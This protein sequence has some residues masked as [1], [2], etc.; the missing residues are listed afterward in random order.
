MIWFDDKGAGGN[1][2]VVVMCVCVCVMCVCAAYM[3]NEVIFYCFIIFLECYTKYHFFSFLFF[4]I[5]RITGFFQVWGLA[6]TETMC[7][8]LE[9]NHCFRT[10]SPSIA[11]PSIFSISHHSGPCPSILSLPIRFIFLICAT[12]FLHCH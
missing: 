5:V 12:V 4:L 2:G 11:G 10:H 9:F 1:S 6:Y 8:A 7:C 3:N